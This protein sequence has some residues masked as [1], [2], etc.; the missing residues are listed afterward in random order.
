MTTAEKLTTIAANQEKVYNAGYE[1]GNTEGGNAV[2]NTFW[3]YYQDSGN[4]TDYQYAFSYSGWRNANFKPK[5]PLTNITNAA[6]MFT[7]C[8]L[9]KIE[10]PLDISNS[11]SAS[12]MFNN[13][14]SLATISEITIG[15]KVTNCSNM[16]A[17]CSALKNIKI[18]GTI[19]CDF[20]MGDCPLNKESIEYVYE[21]LSTSVSG[22][23]CTLKK[24]AVNAAFTDEEWKALTDAKDNWT[25]TLV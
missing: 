22:K 12:M 24:T 14:Q 6:N 1:K 18:L 4:R 8:K 17:S 11:S 19:V 16:F 2:Y 10:V 9:T 23:T 15:T 20:P 21:A 25:F 7:R 3:D 5:Y 13:A